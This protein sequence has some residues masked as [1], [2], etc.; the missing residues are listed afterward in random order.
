MMNSWTFIFLGLIITDFIYYNA[1]ENI[2]NA[3]SIVYIGLLA[4]Y[5]SNKEFERWYDRHEENH[6][7]EIYVL[8]W[9]IIILSLFLLDFIKSGHY[10]VP[11]SVISSYLAVLT[12]LVI[13]RK[14]KELYR[15]RNKKRK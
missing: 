10:R 6:P 3:V 4:I 14:S 15:L 5:V 9:T 2:L 11:N 1:Y 8:V 12:I 13:T 7:G